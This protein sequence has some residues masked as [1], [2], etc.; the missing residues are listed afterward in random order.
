MQTEPDYCGSP[1][2]GV[3]KRTFTV[4]QEEEKNN[5]LVV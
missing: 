3:T 4:H 2:G 5:I 1:F